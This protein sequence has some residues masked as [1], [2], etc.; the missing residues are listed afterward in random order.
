MSKQLQLLATSFAPFWAG[1]VAILAGALALPEVFG[2]ASVALVAAGIFVAL[3]MRAA[4]RPA[5]PPAMPDQPRYQS[6]LGDHLECLHDV[7]WEISESEARYRD[8]LDRQS[9]VILRRDARGKLT[10]VNR[11][12]C[13]TFG[14]SADSVI[15]TTFQPTVLERNEPQSCPDAEP[16]RLTRLVER[17]ETVNGP[18]WFAWEECTAPSGEGGTHEVQHVGRDI[19]EQRAA[20]AILA[21]AREQAE[22][23]NRAKSRFLA[24]MSHEIRTP[25]NGIIGMTD[26]LLATSQTPEQETYARAIEQS[27]K[28]LLVLIDEILDFSKIEAGK[29]ELNV[30]SFDLES[31]IQNAVELLATVAHQKGHEIAWTIDADV[32]RDLIGDEARI[33]QILL[34]LIGN[35]LKF[36]EKGGVLVRVMALSTGPEQAQIAIRVEDTGI[37]IDPEAMAGLFG[38]FEQGDWVGKGRPGGAGLGLAISRRLARAMGG[39]ITVESARGCGSVF[40]CEV[41]LSVDPD[42]PGH[43]DTVKRRR[44]ARVLICSNLEIEKRAL[45]AELGAAGAHV[46]LSSRATEAEAAMSAAAEAGVAF[47]VIIVDAATPPAVAG[48][49]LMHARQL[50]S[51][52]HVRGGVLMTAQE[53]PLLHAFQQAGFDDDLVRPVRRSSLR[54]I[55]D[56]DAKCKAAATP[57]LPKEPATITLPKR[58]ILVA[59]DNAISATLAKC[60]IRRAG[61][62]C[63][64]VENGRAAVEAIQLSLEGDSPA[65]DLV[66]MDV[67]MP[68]YDGLEAAR[69]VRQLRDLYASRQRSAACPPL[70]AVT[71]G[72]FPEDRRACLNAGFDDYLAKPFSWA[73]FEAVLARWLA[74]P[75]P[76]TRASGQS[77]NAA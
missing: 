51:P 65:I 76:A 17:V 24:A 28:T 26:L 45:A 46:S 43:P 2:A 70:I 21:L 62:A 8:L 72:A 15:G 47:D 56:L 73:E 66:L 60:M 25:M 71:A 42:A 20:S 10:F 18:R 1:G 57:K 48:Q 39:D 54:A 63:L 37:G 6:E 77:H 19:T 32:P 59:E 27:A 13:M 14:V 53:R 33:R 50:A 3:A 58:R 64:L 75:Q 23:A 12:F 38:E 36:T 11:A 29:L 52:G 30:A 68:D 55:L 40:T 67:H 44:A 34:N 16:R 7:R 4:L 49:L 69:D 41:S 61:C 5:A 35:A 74:Q 31:C 9:D 22:A